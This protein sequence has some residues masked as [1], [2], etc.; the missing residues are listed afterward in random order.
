[1]NSFLKLAAALLIASSVS[2]GKAQLPATNT[3]KSMH[4]HQRQTPPRPVRK[5]TADSDTFSSG[6][7]RLPKYQGKTN[8]DLRRLGKEPKLLDESKLGSPDAPGALMLGAATTQDL[9]LPAA[10]VRA[11]NNSVSRRVKN[12]GRSILRAAPS[13]GRSLLRRL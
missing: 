11:R 3:G 12:A 7:S 13:T 8:K 10:P 2:P 1:M 6:S 5:A 4:K 9:S